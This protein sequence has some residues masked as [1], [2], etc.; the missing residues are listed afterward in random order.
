MKKF[1]VGFLLMM[2]ALAISGYLQNEDFKTQTELESL[3]GNVS[4]LLN[5]TKIY[6]TADGLNK[7][8]DQA[9]I[10]GDLAGGAGNDLN[11]ASDPSFEKSNANGTCTNCTIDYQ[12]TGVHLLSDTNTQFARM[13]FGVSSTGDYTDT[14]AI[15]SS[16]NNKDA[17]L[18]IAIRTSRTDV[19]LEIYSNSNLKFQ[20]A[21]SSD[22]NW[23]IYEIPFITEST[24]IEFKIDATTASTTAID[25][26]LINFGA[27]PDGY[28]GNISQAQ[29]VGSLL[30]GSANC[31]WASTA[32]SLTSYAVDADCSVI[33]TIGQVSE[34]ATKIPAI[35]IND[36]RTDGTYVVK[37]FGRMVATLSD[38]QC[39]WSLSSSTSYENQQTVILSGV[40]NDSA[41]TISGEFKFSTTGAKTVQ[42]LV[43]R[44]LGTGSCN[45]AAD[46]NGGIRNMKLTVEFMPDSGDK[47]VR[48]RT[49]LDATTANDF[50]AKVTTAGVVT[51]ENHD[52]INGN[53]SNIGTGT[54]ECTY[55]ASIFTQAPAVVCSAVNTSSTSGR[56]CEVVATTSTSAIIYLEN[57]TGAGHTGRQNGDFEIVVSKQ[58]VDVVKGIE[59]AGVF[60]DTNIKKVADVYSSTEVEWGVWNGSPLYRRC[61]TVPS[62]ITVNNTLI[63]TFATGLFIKDSNNYTGSNWALA[64]ERSPDGTNTVNIIYNSSDGTIRAFIGGTY[65]VGA[66]YSQC[67]EYTK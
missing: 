30:W 50:S 49:L 48:Q 16:F 61:F 19:N 58:G 52:F 46:N 33:D 32:A 45:I 51:S 54:Y 3:G 60:R 1:I 66:G 24:D 44:N 34:P 21:V 23:H 38:T 26:D 59:V 41:N 31:S 2:S 35:R 10:D 20:R 39:R 11:I 57:I 14:Y 28:I 22:G 42:L 55:N 65:Q 56:L 43:E 12:T 25:M 15:D 63:T 36:A 13:N 53:C 4:Q 18:R 40:T 64:R 5:D 62:T 6:L 9:I 7:R 29:F 8:L 67:I 47:T 27:L 17:F 37:L